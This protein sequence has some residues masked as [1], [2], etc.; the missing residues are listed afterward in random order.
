MKKRS[1]A[2]L[3]LMLLVILAGCAPKD[4]PAPPADLDI[5]TIALSVVR[6]MSNGDFAAAAEDHAYTGKMRR[7]ISEKFLKEQVWEYLV[8]NY[9]AYEGFN[10][11]AFSQSG[12]YETVTVP[13]TFE[14]GI[15]NINVTFDAKRRIA[16]IHSVPVE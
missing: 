14:D 12:G 16:G 6:D 10:E 4:D 15:V 11:P 9:G 7:V 1:I 13:A 2:L 5:G 8:A 3:A